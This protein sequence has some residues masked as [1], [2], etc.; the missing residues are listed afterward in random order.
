MN[1]LKIYLQV[2]RLSRIHHRNLVP[3]TGPKFWTLSFL[4]FEELVINLV[5]WW[6]FILC[7]I[8]WL[9]LVMGLVMFWIGSRIVEWLGL[10]VMFW[11]G[12][13]IVEWLLG[14]CTFKQYLLKI[15]IKKRCI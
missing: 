7:C 13:R 14:F 1:S 5:V 11:I 6:W 3:L 8:L 12:S 9:E 15:L 2:A 4:A 10:L